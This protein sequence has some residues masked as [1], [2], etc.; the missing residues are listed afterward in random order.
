M[1]KTTYYQRNKEKC[2]AK[3]KR[4]WNKGRNK[5]RYKEMK[6]KSRAKH[7]V[8][9]LK[10]ERELYQQN[11][12]K[13]LAQ[14]RDRRQR[15]DVKAKEH[16]YYVKVRDITRA[17][18]LITKHKGKPKELITP[19]FLY[20]FRSITPG[21]YKVGFT[22]DWNTR[23]NNYSGPSAIKDLFFVR[24]VADMRYA[25]TQL[26]LFLHAHGLYMLVSFKADWFVI[27]EEKVF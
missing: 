4:W 22:K 18:R 24:P 20:F 14:K 17:R 9:I 19:G 27:E 23:K 12:T 25:E 10:R 21:Y 26:K 1:V 13:V 3:F 2:R 8:R 7:H 16:A 11:R 5:E 6:K 15:P